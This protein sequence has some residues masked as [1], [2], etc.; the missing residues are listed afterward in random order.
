MITFRRWLPALVVFLIGSVT[1]VL[2]ASALSA[3]F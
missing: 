3:G 2:V 1:L